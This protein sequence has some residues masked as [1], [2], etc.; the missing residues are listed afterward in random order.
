MIVTLDIMTVS[1]MTSRNQYS[2]CTLLES[3]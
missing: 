2:V 1:R 3:F